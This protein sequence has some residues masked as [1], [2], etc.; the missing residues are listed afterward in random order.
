MPAAAETPEWKRRLVNGEDIAS[1]GFDLFSPSKLEGIFKH[2][3][4][5]ILPSDNDAVE[6]DGSIRR[7]PFNMPI[8][9]TFPEQYSS[10]RGTRSRLNLAVLEEINEEEESEH[11]NHP[12]GPHP[13]L[14]RGSIQEL[15]EQRM[16]SLARTRSGNSTPASRPS[17]PENESVIQRRA[18]SRVPDPR[19][20]TV[21]GQE[22]LRNEFISPVTMSK[23]NS[24]R[25]TIMRNPTN[26]DIQSLDMLLREAA[27]D[28]PRP[29]SSSSDRDVS[30][31]NGDGAQHEPARVDELLPDLTSQS[32]PDDLSMGTQDFVAGGGFINSRRGGRSND[33]SFLRKS[34]SLSR[35]HSKVDSQNR[36][37]FTFNSSPPQSSRFWDD[38]IDQSK[39]SASAPGT[40]P[41]TSVVHHAESRSRPTSS[42]SPLKL[43]GNR[44]TYTNNKLMR[45]LS[46]FEPDTRCDESK[47]NDSAD[48]DHDNVFRMSQFG[49]GELDGFG[50][51]QNVRRPSPVDMGHVGLDDRIFQPKTAVTTKQPQV[52]EEGDFSGNTKDAQE[53]DRLTKRR[54]TLMQE[55]VTI[56]DN[57][58]EVK[59]SSLEEKATLAGK[60]RTD[61]RP[62]SDPAQAEPEVLATR[63]LLKPKSARRSS[64]GKS[65]TEN[66]T[67]TDGEEEALEDLQH[68]LTEALAAELATF[69]HEAVKVKEDSRKPSLA[70]KDYMEEANKVMQFI[71]ARGKPVPALNEMSEPVNASELNADAILDLSIDADSTKDDFS[72]PPSREYSAKPSPERRHARHDSRTASYLKKYQDQD[73]LDVLASTSVF[74]TWAPSDNRLAAEAASVPVPD[75][76]QESDPP[77]IRIRGHNEAMRKRK[78]STS[79][80][81]GPVSGQSSLQHSFPTNSSAASGQKGVITSGTV[82][83]PDKVGAMTFDHDK[84]IWVK[85]MQVAQSPKVVDLEGVSEGDPFENIPDLSIDEK[86]EIRSRAR[87]NQ[88]AANEQQPIDLPP[89]PTSWEEPPPPRRPLQE[90][91][92]E[93]VMKRDQALTAPRN[94]D[95]DDANHS[96]LR[97]KVSEYE[98]KLQSGVPSKPPTELKENRKQAR[99]VTIAFS[100]PVVSGINYANMSDED[101]EALPR[102]DDLP[103]DESYI[104]LDDDI[105]DVVTSH[106]AQNKFSTTVED[107]Q[108]LTFQPRTISPIE[109]QD[110][111]QSAAQMRMVN[112]SRFHELTPAAPRTIVKLQKS[113]Q[114]S[115]SILC[116]TPL[117]DF[118]LHQVDKGR[119]SDQSYVEDRKHPSALRQAHGSLALAV[120]QLVRAI[121]DAVK[122]EL[123]W[124]E[125]R[126]LKL[127]ENKIS[128]VH[129]LKE[130][131]P[132]LEHL[133]VSGNQLRQLDGLPS[134][135]RILDIQNNM[136][137]DLSSWNHLHNL[138]YLDV[139]GN[140]LENLECF[141]SLVHLRTLKADNNRIT[142]IDGILDLDSLLELELNDNEL[143]DVNFEGSELTRLRVL[144]LR[145]NKLKK[146]NSLRSLPALESLDVSNNELEEFGQDFQGQGL[147]LKELRLSHNA[148]EA[149]HVNLM[150]ALRHLDLDNNKIKSIHGLSLAYDLEFLSLRK[151]SDSAHIV[152]LILST[153]NECRTIR[154]SSNSV[155][156][157]MFK[158]PTSPQNNLRELEIA[159]CGIAELPEGFGAAFPNCRSLNANFNAIKDIAPLRRM[160]HLKT[161]LLAKNRVK[162]LRRTCL[163]LSRLGS[164]KQV[165]LR[166]N[167]LTVGFYSPVQ[168]V[169]DADR[170]LS[171]ARYH[172]PQGSAAED[173]NWLKLLD[174]VTGMK[175]RTIELLLADHCKGLVELDGLCFCRGQSD[176]EDETWAKLTDQRVLVKPVL[177]QMPTA[178]TAEK[179]PRKDGDIS[180]CPLREALATPRVE[181]S[182]IMDCD[183]FDG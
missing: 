127:D 29:T 43:F 46:H 15:A 115:A 47:S 123:F 52:D 88:I 81:E 160:V 174:E 26:V 36:D 25:E 48:E 8:S 119:D 165:D 177:V 16:R 162:K 17:S 163:V 19:W 84:R 129:A 22:E 157:G 59:I 159:A 164:L 148:L 136:L 65:A 104:N 116:L 45:I 85:K 77:N 27:Y 111:E 14:E 150:P 89:T 60:K 128:S 40:P 58:L 172:L 178:N 67:E 68:D 144:D 90:L 103:L 133:S 182:M 39:I 51:E 95:E 134:T 28:P 167:P 183:V 63:N 76:F 23:Q 181:G 151:Q 5:S 30:Y 75:E 87:Q 35:E 32:L 155:T 53:R 56:D 153:P 106:H 175:R 110:E 154:L 57:E 83:I 108:A 146:V 125:L 9:N 74:G 18:S 3:T 135:L 121:T 166:D 91:E 145:N 49:Q 69:T 62:G 98:V 156:S 42:G 1:D 114:K 70:T 86:Q 132:V 138:Q 120:D 78:H 99:V 170:P 176:R 64:V 180:I 109:E 12:K 11:Q 173:A 21:S 66:T 102:E 169:V 141:S 117:S 101:F 142:N 6:N 37:N 61:A 147:I 20:R 94:E 143:T 131:C 10:V 161:L 54:K 55:Q 168:N 112:S 105:E 50:F 41:D 158:L 139:S 96:S 31:G 130:Y 97:S 44:D 38:S 152:D 71:R 93:L 82:S 2:P 92:P 126:R 140:E 33:N 4:S 149:I 79:T 124:E 118:S 7:K 179:M 73:D 100:S 122:D 72:R 13:T 24:I 34:L 107:R 80:I 137:N 113:G 171:E